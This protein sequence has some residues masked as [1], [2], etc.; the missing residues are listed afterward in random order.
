MLVAQYKGKTITK[1]SLTLVEL[2]MH[3]V[4]LKK[5]KLR[6]KYDFKNNIYLTPSLYQ[7]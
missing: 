1:S 2:K 5:K 4:R 3:L 7:M 6:E